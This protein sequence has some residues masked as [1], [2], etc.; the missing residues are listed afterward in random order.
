M[1][2]ILFVILTLI[3]I[4]SCATT[5]C[6]DGRKVKFGKE[7]RHQYAVKGME[8]NAKAVLN[9]ISNSDAEISLKRNIEKIIE[10]LQSKHAIVRDALDN[11]YRLAASDPCLESKTKAYNELVLKALQE[12]RASNEAT[13]ELV[14]QIESDNISGSKIPTIESIIKNYIDESTFN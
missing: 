11:S 8:A 12:L 5:K 4:N 3:L 6:P 10:P 7:P 1:K 14:E 9:A 13:E 2:K